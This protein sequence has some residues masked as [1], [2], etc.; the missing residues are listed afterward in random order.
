MN[1]VTLKIESVQTP[2]V[3]SYNFFIIPKDLGGV[4]VKYK[5]LSFDCPNLK[6][7]ETIIGYLLEKVSF[8][9]EDDYN[10]SIIRENETVFKG[11]VEDINDILSS[12]LPL[13]YVCKDLVI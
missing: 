6:I 8:S 9:C 4:I 7:Y 5:T 11:E 12:V 13:F 2:S 3:F 10:I 1:T